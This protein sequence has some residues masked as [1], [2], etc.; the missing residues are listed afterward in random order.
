M[1]IRNLASK[2][3]KDLKS[4]T[5]NEIEKRKK[6]LRVGETPRTLPLFIIRI[7]NDLKSL[8]MVVT[9]PEWDLALMFSQVAKTMRLRVMRAVVTMNMEKTLMTIA[10][11][12]LNP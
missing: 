7:N 12:I 3:A 11:V 8:L 4:S 5:T 6:R 1:T 2:I 10:S 9:T